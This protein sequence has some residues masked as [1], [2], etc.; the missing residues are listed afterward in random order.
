[1]KILFIGKREDKAAEKAAKELLQLFPNTQ[2]VWSHRSIKYPE[3]LKSW[4][5]DYIFSYLAQWIIPAATLN[6]AKV[7]ALNWHPGPPQYP[8]IGCTNFAVYNQ[9]SEF[10]I[11]CHHMNPKVDTG[12]LV[13]VRR[14]PVQPNDSVFT[15]TENCYKEI[16]ASFS[17]IIK[18]IYAAQPLPESTEQWT[19]KPYRRTE[20]DALCVLTPDMSKEEM[21][22]RIKATKYDRHWAFLELYGIKFMPVDD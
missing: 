13:E 20:L 12:S 1:M 2:V 6:G 18:G 11:T 8:G 21:Q 22:L 10:G 16:A 17:S 3:E 19:R 4:T 9:E 14:F 7:A 15:I 5:G